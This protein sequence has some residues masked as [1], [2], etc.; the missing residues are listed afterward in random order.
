LGEI[1]IMRQVLC[2][3]VETPQRARS[4]VEFEEGIVRI[5]RD[6]RSDVRLPFRGISRLHAVLEFCDGDWLLQDVQSTNGTLINGV[7]TEGTILQPGDVISIG[8]CRLHLSVEYRMDK[9]SPRLEP[10]TTSHDQPAVEALCS[11]NEN[12]LREWV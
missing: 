11:T 6:P 7:P 3:Q 1:A 8:A 9:T 12:T 2:V 10:V 5:G 4:Y